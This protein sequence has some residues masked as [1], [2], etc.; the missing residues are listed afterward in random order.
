MKLKLVCLK[1]GQDIRPGAHRSIGHVGIA[2]AVVERAF[3]P[4]EVA[5]LYG[6]NMGHYEPK[7]VAGD[8][9]IHYCNGVR[10][11]PVLAEVIEAEWMEDKPFIPNLGHVPVRDCSLQPT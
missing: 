11:I 10:T 8:V 3:P 5:P 2:Y 4:N 9:W 1:T 7:P 6:P